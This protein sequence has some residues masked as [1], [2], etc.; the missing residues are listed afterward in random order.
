MSNSLEVDLNTA[1]LIYSTN[2]VS[3]TESE[4]ST[5]PG[6]RTQASICDPDD[7]ESQQG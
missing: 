1:K 3:Y 4:P 7:L 5:G 6:G 2:E